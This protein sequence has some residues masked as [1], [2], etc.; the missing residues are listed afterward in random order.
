MIDIN[1]LIQNNRIAAMRRN[2]EEN[3]TN[4]I[5]EII[6]YVVDKAFNEGYQC[7]KDDAYAELNPSDEIKIGDEVIN[8]FGQVGY[9]TN[10]DDTELCVLYPYGGVG[11]STIDT[12]KKTNRHSQQIEK[13]LGIINGDEAY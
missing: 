8:I 5:N 6:K 3:I 9:V 10:I 12:Y 13:L 4:N 2:I 11:H 1:K 7:G